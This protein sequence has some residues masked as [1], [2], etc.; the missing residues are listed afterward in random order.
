MSDGERALSLCAENMPDVIL[1]E[2][3]MAKMGGLEFLEQLAIL[4]RARYSEAPAILFCLDRQ[5]PD[6]MGEAV[7]KGATECLL[8]PYDADILDFKLQQSGAI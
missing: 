5:D 1:V 7:W 4:R 2:S 8:N 3:T 6:A